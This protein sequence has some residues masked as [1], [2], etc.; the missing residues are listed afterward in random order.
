MAMTNAERQKKFRESKLGARNNN[1]RLQTI[2]D[3]KTHAE[4]ERIVFR[5]KKSKQEAIAQ[6]IHELAE[7]LGCEVSE[8]EK[9]YH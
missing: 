6:A 5:L 4:L 7:K 8:W 9:E 3:M 1:Y 2:I